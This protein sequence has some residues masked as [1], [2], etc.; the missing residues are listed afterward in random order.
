MTQSKKDED[1]GSGNGTEEPTGAAAEVTEV[2]RR[3]AVVRALAAM[4]SIPAAET[5][6]AAEELG[7]SSSRLND[8][9]RAWRLHGRISTATR[10][11]PQKDRI[12]AALA[13]AEAPLDLSDVDPARRQE[14]ARRIGIIARYLRS[15]APDGSF[16]RALADEYGTTYRAFRTAINA[17]VTSPEPVK[18]PG[19]LR[20]GSA[21]VAG[22]TSMGPIVEAALE[23][24]IDELGRDA[25]AT[26]VHR[27]VAQLCHAEGLAAP[28]IGLI[29]RRLL[30]ARSASPAPG[31]DVTIRLDRVRV[32]WTGSAKPLA[33]PETLTILFGAT[34]GRVL[35]HHLG[36]RPSAEVDALVLARHAAEAV[37]R[38]PLILE[39]PFPPGHRWDRLIDLLAA[40]AVSVLRSDRRTSASGRLARSTFGDSIG[41]LRFG[42]IDR[43]FLPGRQEQALVSE[44]RGI[45]ERAIAEHNAGRSPEVGPLTAKARAEGLARSLLALAGPVVG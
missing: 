22:G 42:R 14:I 16:A 36:D 23:Q 15:E 12:A 21:G 10:G 20:I 24:A 44:H 26:L 31:P 5:A 25:G 34:S 6:R 41:P 37:D 1:T 19:A 29:Y 43:R 40:G 28:T 7:I 13:V 45:V 38:R 18:L 27:R 17:W 30:R 39:M 32:L 3:I 2:E 9:V 8:L 11:R 33:A 4:P 35:A